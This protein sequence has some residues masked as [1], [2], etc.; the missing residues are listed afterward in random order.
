MSKEDLIAENEA[1]K[2][3]LVAMSNELSMTAFSYNSFRS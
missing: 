3:K 1:L 2:A